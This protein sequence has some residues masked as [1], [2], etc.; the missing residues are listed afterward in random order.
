M[1]FQKVYIDVKVKSNVLAYVA[2]WL[3]NESLKTNGN[4]SCHIAL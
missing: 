4:S 2:G 1:I 3:K